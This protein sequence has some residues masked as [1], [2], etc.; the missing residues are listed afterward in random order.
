MQTWF[1][2][3]ED[4][5]ISEIQNKE[6]NPGNDDDDDDTEKNID[7]RTKKTP[8]KKDKCKC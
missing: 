4:N 8:K 7:I 2:L 1:G 3:M 6:D 5:M